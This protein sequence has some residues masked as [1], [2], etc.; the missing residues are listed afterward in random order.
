MCVWNT[1]GNCH[2]IY[3]SCTQTDECIKRSL[4]AREMKHPSVQKHTLTRK[5]TNSDRIVVVT[6]FD[7]SIPF[8]LQ[9]FPPV[10][11]CVCS[12]YIMKSLH[13]CHIATHVKSRNERESVPVIQRNAIRFY[14]S[15][16]HSKQSQTLRNVEIHYYYRLQTNI[17]TANYAAIVTQPRRQLIQFRW[18]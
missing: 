9:C 3:S 11:L 8:L 12:H 4:V 16:A 14:V 17:N 6:V 15:L 10:L 7:F 5:R 2:H 13:V 18:I 1:D